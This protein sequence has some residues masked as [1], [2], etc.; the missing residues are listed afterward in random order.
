MLGL[1]QAPALPQRHL[2][3]QIKALPGPLCNDPAHKGLALAAVV[4]VSG[5]KIVHACVPRGVQ[6]RF[7]PGLVNGSLWCGGEPHTAIAQQGGADA[8]PCSFLLF[9]RSVFHL[10]CAAGCRVPAAP[11]FAPSIPEKSA[12]TRKMF[13]FLFC[14]RKYGILIIQILSCYQLNQIA[15][16]SIMEPFNTPLKIREISPAP[17][18]SVRPHGGL[19]YRCP[20]P[21][22]DGPARSRFYRQ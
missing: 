22:A 12:L 15:L 2:G 4:G 6:Q 10:F 19:F 13:R 17:P 8:L 20:G 1:L 11:P 7:G 3:G 21:A 5:V 9:P 18:G 14:R 16:R